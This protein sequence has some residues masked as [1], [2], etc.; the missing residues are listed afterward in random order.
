M[1][2]MTRRRVKWHAP[3]G[4]RLEPHSMAS[5]SHFLLAAESTAACERLGPGGALHAT[6]HIELPRIGQRA[7]PVHSR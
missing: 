7:T 4:V 1:I 6:Q 5:T 2:R 3:A